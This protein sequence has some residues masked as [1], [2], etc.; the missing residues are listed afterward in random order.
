MDCKNSLNL[1]RLMSLHG[2]CTQINEYC[3]NAKALA[4]TCS[5]SLELC[6]TA[7]GF[8]GDTASNTGAEHRLF[9]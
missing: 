3:D 7:A 1:L 6:W 4:L 8:D 9:G 2:A 5:S